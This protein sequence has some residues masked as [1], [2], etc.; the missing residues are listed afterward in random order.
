MS[1]FEVAGVRIH[2][3]P[4]R[5]TGQTVVANLVIQSGA[6]IV[7][8]VSLVLMDSGEY[9]VFLPKFNDHRRV[10]LRS[11]V[12]FPALLEAALTAYRALGGASAA[13]AAR[14]GIKAEHHH[15]HHP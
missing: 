8:G 12:G 11:S 2:N 6:F 10:A 4:H 7:V 9:R 15:G 5:Q 14:D 13:T 3:P 1:D